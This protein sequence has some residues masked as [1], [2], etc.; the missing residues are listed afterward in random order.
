MAR[1]PRF[2]DVNYYSSLFLTPT[3]SDE[4]IKTAH[5]KLQ[6]W[7]HPDTKNNDSF[8]TSCFQRVQ[9][10][11]NVLGD[12]NKRKFYDEFRSQSMVPETK[13][14]S[15]KP[16]A[17]KKEKTPPDYKKSRVVFPYPVWID[18]ERRA[19]PDTRTGEKL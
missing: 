15:P 3:A 13:A 12:T 19:V 5:K 4:E 8:A 9:E 1:K 11:Y 17:Q 6:K 18:L 16:G 2:E 14:E 10:A 7:L